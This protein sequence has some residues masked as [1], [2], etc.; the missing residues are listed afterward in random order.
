MIVKQKTKI[1]Y[2]KGI[3]D[4]Q[5]MCERKQN[6]YVI[7]SCKKDKKTK[8]HNNNNNNNKINKK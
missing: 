3:F 5:Q 2:K 7:I 8:N 4:D 1:I 6:K